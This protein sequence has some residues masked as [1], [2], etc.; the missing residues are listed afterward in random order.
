MIDFLLSYLLPRSDLRALCLRRKSHRKLVGNLPSDLLPRTFTFLPVL[1]LASTQT[2]I[3]S[4]HR[5]VPPFV[6]TLIKRT[7]PRKSSDSIQFFDQS[8][9]LSEIQDSHR[10]GPRVG[11]VSD[12]D[13]TY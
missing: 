3:I 6:Y 12:G 4:K 13:G 8:S 9:K 1:G 10:I 2:G 11:R 5:V 7:S